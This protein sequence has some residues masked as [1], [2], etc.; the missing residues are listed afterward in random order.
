MDGLDTNA[1]VKH[2][3]ETG[4]RGTP[5]YVQLREALLRTIEGGHWRPGDQLPSEQDL[6]ESLPVSLGTVQKTLRWLADEGIVVRKHGQG[7]FVAGT[8]QKQ[9]EGIWHFRFVDD[10]GKTLLPVFSRV[11]GRGLVKRNGPWT[12]FLGPDSSGYLR[13]TRLLNINEE[14]EVYSEFYLAA[15]RFSPLL[16]MPLDELHGVNFKHVLSKHF[17][18]PTFHVLQHIR[19]VSMPIKVCDAIGVARDT[20]GLRIEV[21]GRTYRDAPLSYQVIYVPPNGRRLEMPG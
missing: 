9:M 10:N 18:A 7:T 11:T 3:A 20:Y 13:V 19:C 12:E 21:F 2:F 1:F 17:N 8:Y 4:G 16:E 5:K 14:F 15:A 6:A